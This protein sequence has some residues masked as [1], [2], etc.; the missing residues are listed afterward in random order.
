MSHVPES[1]MTRANTGDFDLAKMMSDLERVMS[2]PAS[3]C[4]LTLFRR[5]RQKVQEQI[6]TLEDVL[7]SEDEDLS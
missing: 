5:K 1:R 3:P 6:D 2:N 4:L 7:W